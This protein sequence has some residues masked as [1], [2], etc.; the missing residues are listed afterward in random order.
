M[1]KTQDLISRERKKERKGGERKR[2]E[3]D[4]IGSDL[5]NTIGLLNKLKQTM[6]KSH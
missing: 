5:F 4:G 3:E 6:L 2:E 1:Q